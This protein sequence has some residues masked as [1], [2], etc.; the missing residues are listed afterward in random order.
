MGGLNHEVDGSRCGCSVWIGDK[1]TISL[2]GAVPSHSP[3]DFSL[4][5]G[6]YYNL[7]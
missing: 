7:D 4:C 3:D 5:T 1:G 6:P 2:A